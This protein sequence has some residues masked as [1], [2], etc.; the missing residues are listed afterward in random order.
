MAGPDTTQPPTRLRVAARPDRGGATATLERADDTW[1]VELDDAAVDAE[2]GEALAAELLAAAADAV[3][4]AGGGSLHHWVRGADAR[5]ASVSVAAGMAPVRAVWQM[6]RSLPV[7]EPAEVE[8]R[9]FVVGQDETAWLEVN[10]RAFAWHPEQGDRTLDELLELERAAWF[11]PAGFLL[12]E[13][14]GRLLGFCWTKVHADEQP[15][16]GEIYVIA[17]DPS[18]H[19]RGLGRRLVLAGLD[20][21]H[22]AGLACGMLYVEST[23]EAA[24][25]L[26]RDLGFERHRVDTA[27]AMEVPAR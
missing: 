19:R 5:R 3:A 8:V 1:T 7:D 2:A 17:V 16:L 13:E 12:H 11:D 24:I 18:A 14:G 6:R 26:Y 10:H 9:P 20:H 4:G 27:Y 21:L 25:R 23:N 22:R 15:P